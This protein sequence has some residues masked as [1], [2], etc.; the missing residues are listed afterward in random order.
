MHE[1]LTDRQ[2]EVLALIDAAVSAGT[3]PPS[4]CE[5]AE[6]LQMWPNTVF[7]HL[8]ALR[9]KGFLRERDRKARTLE[10][11]KRRDGRRCLIAGRWY[12]LILVEEL[13]PA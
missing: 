7:G 11:L 10:I 5:I 12:E 8:R 4:V 3:V 2:A 6:A 9:K 13:Y 1:P